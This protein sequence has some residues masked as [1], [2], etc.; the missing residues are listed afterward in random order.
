MKMPDE[1]K[2]LEKELLTCVRCGSCKVLCPTHQHGALE[3]VSA[4]GRLVLLQGLLTGAIKPSPLLNER[5]FSCILCGACAG[6]C[7]LGIDIPEAIYRGRALLSKTDKER[8]QLRTVAKI[9]TRWP[10]ASFRMLRMSQQLVLPFLYKKGLITYNNALAYADSV[11][12]LR[13]R[14]KIDE[15]GD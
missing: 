12:D 8:K 1:L 7:P 14:I 5:I 9:S 3:V 10:D 15:V 11:N 6:K 4:R 2:H 13:L